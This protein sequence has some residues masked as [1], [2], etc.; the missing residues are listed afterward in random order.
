LEGVG[1]MLSVV[2]S[3]KKTTATTETDHEN[4]NFLSSIEV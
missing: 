2:D 4:Q 3:F 1:Q